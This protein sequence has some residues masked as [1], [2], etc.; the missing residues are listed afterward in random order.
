MNGI[1]EVLEKAERERI[2]FLCFFE[3][4]L[5]GYYEEEELAAQTALEVSS[6]DF[7]NWLA[8]TSFFTITFII[9]FNEREGNRIYDSAAIVEKGKLLGIQR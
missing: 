9:G 7:Q 1:I 2:D 6:I 8:G 3:G 5:T 4:F